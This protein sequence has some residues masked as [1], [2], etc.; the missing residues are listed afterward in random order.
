MWLV[1]NVPVCKQTTSFRIQWLRIKLMCNKKRTLSE[2]KI[3]ML[4]MSSIEDN[5][6]TIAPS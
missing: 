2:H 1:V 6:D 5:R 4:A 3:D